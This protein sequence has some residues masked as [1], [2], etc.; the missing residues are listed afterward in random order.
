[1]PPPADTTT[2][3]S[4]SS[5]SSSEPASATRSWIFGDSHADTHHFDEGALVRAPQEVACAAAAAALVSPLV[6]I[7]DK[8]LVRNISGAS[9]FVAALQGAT[10]QMAANPG[11]FV[12]GLGF[13]LTFAVYFGTYAVA[14]LAELALD[15]RGVEGDDRRREAR[16]AA[17]GVANIGLLAW[18]D[19]AFARAYS[20]RH[21]TQP[22]R[23]TPLR[24]LACFATRDMAT[25]YATFYLAPRAADHLRE[26]YGWERNAAELSTALAVPVAMQALTA[27]FH[28]HAMDFYANPEQRPL[29]ARLGTVRREFATV[30]TARGFRFL[31]AFGLGSFANNRLREAFIHSEGD[32]QPPVQKRIQKR[33]TSIMPR[34]GEGIGGGAPM[35]A[36]SGAG[37]GGA[38]AAAAAAAADPPSA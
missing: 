3:S 35:L 26:R 17:S 20:P 14:N 5:S 9:R 22:P 25:I 13:R 31:P 36:S 18:R 30:A 11:R 29:S 23:P 24:S 34:D 12:G 1:M 38:A 7:I 28:I 37:A 19:A 16:A 33:I 32:R 4:S 15:G 10:V 6:S 2:F 27:P 21:P 8:S